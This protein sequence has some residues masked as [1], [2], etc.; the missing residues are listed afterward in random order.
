MA[1]RNEEDRY[2][3]QV[4]EHA[5]QY[6]DKFVIIDDASTDNTIDIIESALAGTEYVLIRNDKSLFENEVMLRKKQWN[7]TIA[8]NPDWIMF[9]D[10]DDM[11]DDEIIRVKKWLMDNNSVDAYCFRLYDFWKDG[12]YRDDEYWSAHH[13]Y[14]PFMIR[15]QPYFKYRFKNFRQH[16][17]RMP[18]NILMLPFVNLPTIKVK[19]FGWLRDDDKINKYNRYRLLDPNGKFGNLKQYDSILDKEPNLVKF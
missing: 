17:G 19:H 13:R 9:L 7:C 1:V 18:K 16:C 14:T 10:A 2:L 15:Y 11:L 12:Y 3:R 5:K 4:L 6:I 8:T